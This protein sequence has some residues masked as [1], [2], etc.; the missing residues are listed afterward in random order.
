MAQ[1]CLW[2]KPEDLSLIPRTCGTNIK[3]L[4]R[5]HASGVIAHFCCRWEGRQDT[6]L[7]VHPPAHLEP[8]VPQQWQER[9][10]LEPGRE[11]IHERC[12]LSFTFIPWHVQ[13]QSHVC[14]YTY[15]REETCTQRHTCVHTCTFECTR[16]CI[17]THT[18]TC[19][20]THAHRYAH[21]DTR[22]YTSRCMLL[23][24]HTHTFIHTCSHT[25]RCTLT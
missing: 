24:E 11:L 25:L 16:I 10:C 14:K 5:W 12:L 6:D 20:Y 4:M 15:K 9:L 8:V 1:Q 13:P 23:R 3:R 2:P 7:A 21:T 19:E 18:R 22:A 17:D